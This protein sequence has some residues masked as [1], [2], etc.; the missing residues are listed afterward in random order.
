[1]DRRGA[2]SVPA[3][4]RRG[5]LRRAH[6]RPD[7]AAARRG[8]ARRRRGAPPGA[9][10]RP[11]SAGRRVRAQARRQAGH[12][13]RAGPLPL[14][15]ARLPPRRCAS[16]LGDAP[17][18]RR[19]ARAARR[20]PRHRLG[21]PRHGPRAPRGQGRLSGDPQPPPPERRGRHDALGHRV[22]GR[23]DPARPRD[24]DRRDAGRRGRPPALRGRADLRLR[25]QPDPALPR[26]APVPV[27][28]HARPRLR[29]QDLPGTVG[30]RAPPG[31]ARG[32][33][34]EA[35]ALRRRDLRD[36][37]RLPAPPRHG[38]RDRRPRLPA[39][40]AGPQ[41]GNHSRGLP[42]AA[43]ALGRRPAGAAGDPLRSGVRGGGPA[44]GAPLRR[45]GRAR[46]RR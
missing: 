17:A 21:R 22:R 45:G 26:A 19:G 46:C 38:P 29:Q 36:R 44:R 34:R 14:A 40:P 43:A 32:D 4:E 13:D 11:R 42:P 2:G 35:L 23:P 37:R 9:R 5:D 30:A 12:R 10:P 25:A 33:D 6:R 27:L 31:S 15:R 41:G 3:L 7:E 28:R 18:H 39:L 20:L 16:R 8:A 24:R 1:M